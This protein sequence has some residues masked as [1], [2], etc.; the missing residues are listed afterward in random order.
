MT[1]PAPHKRRLL[2]A[3]W[4]N[5]VLFCVITLYLP[6]GYSKEGGTVVPSDV[7]MITDVDDLGL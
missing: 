7:A 2:E 3:E 6:T 4:A 1:F 5:H